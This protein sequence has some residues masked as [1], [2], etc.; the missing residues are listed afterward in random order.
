MRARKADAAT[1]QRHGVPGGEARELLQDLAN[2]TAELCKSVV[3]LVELT[4][5]LPGRR[6]EEL[7][8]AAEALQASS[9]DRHELVARAVQR[10]C[11]GRVLAREKKPFKRER[12]RA[13]DIKAE[14]E[15]ARDRPFYA[16][17]LRRIPLPSIPLTPPPKP[18][19]AMPRE[20]YE[21]LLSLA[22]DGGRKPNNA[23]EVSPPKVGRPPHGPGA[24]QTKP[25]EPKEAVALTK[26]PEEISAALSRRA[27]E[28][29][30]QCMTGDGSLD[31][32]R[33]RC[34]LL[35]GSRR[36]NQLTLSRLPYEAL[37]RL[38][39]GSPAEA[40]G[41][42]AEVVKGLF[43][44]DT[45]N[46]AM[47]AEGGR[48]KR[49]WSQRPLPEADAAER[50]T[51]IGAALLAD[52]VPLFPAAVRAIRPRPLDRDEQR[53]PRVEPGGEPLRIVGDLG[54]FRALLSLFSNGL[55][56]RIPWDA[57]VVLGGSAVTAC[58][59]V[60]EGVLEEWS[61]RLRHAALWH[62][63]GAIRS[64]LIKCLG[65]RNAPGSLP[66]AAL[67]LDFAHDRRPPG[68]EALGKRLFHNEAGA[69]YNLADIDLFFVAPTKAKAAASLNRVQLELQSA[70]ERSQSGTG[71]GRSHVAVRTPN[72]VT[73]CPRFPLRHVQL[74]LRVAEDMGEH[75]ANADLDCTSVCY[76]GQTVWATPRAIRAFETGFNLVSNQALLQRK[77]L[78][79]R[80]A[81]YAQ[82]GFGSM[83]YEL[84]RHEPR[85]DVEVDEK[86]RAK[87]EAARRPRRSPGFTKVP[88][89][90]NTAEVMVELTMRGY[91]LL[92]IPRGPAVTPEAISLY[93]E[94]REEGKRTLTEVTSEVAWGGLA[95]WRR[96]RP[97]QPIFGEE[98]A[99][100][101]GAPQSSC[102]CCGSVCS[103]DRTG[104]NGAT[105]GALAEATRPA[106]SDAEAV[107]GDIRE[108]AEAST[109]GG[110]PSGRLSVVPICQVC[111]DMNADRRA[112]AVDLR[113]YT[114][115]VTGG[116]CK[117]GYEA[118]LKLLRCGALVVAST[119]FP[120]CAAQNFLSEPD[121]ASW[122]GR[123]HIYGIDFSDLSLLRAFIAQ[124]ARYYPV[125]IL[126]NN[127][128]QT[129]RRPTAY[130][131]Q[132]FERE[133][134]LLADAA[135]GGLRTAE[136]VRPVGQSPWASGRQMATPP[137][138]AAA[139]S[140][141]HPAAGPAD[142]TSAVG[143]FAVAPPALG[144][145][146]VASPT[147]EAPAWGTSTVVPRQ[148]LLDAAG[149]ETAQLFPAGRQ[150]LHGEPL[151]LRPSSSWTAT[152][153][154]GGVAE[155]ELL[156]VLAVNAAAPFM[157][158]QGLLPVLRQP[159]AGSVGEES[160]A[161]EGRFIVNVTSA[162]GIFSMDG[163]AS[164]TAEHPH[165]NMAK[166][167]LNMLTKTS[168]PE[169]SQYGIYC[170]AV[171]PG[172]VSMMRPGSPFEAKRPLPPL[173]V[174]DGAARV[175][176]PIMDG[177][178]ALRAGRRPLHG[179]LFRNYVVAPW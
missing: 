125:D 172:W 1:Q 122:V 121:A 129:I 137:A 163:S 47:L 161:A 132:L 64:A 35:A 87:L 75:L 126:V 28:E 26:E 49:A 110:K 100:N 102:Y 170:T 89:A 12:L 131:A 103:S 6:R 8:T 56:D 171:D 7:I 156:E 81:K 19:V 62:C 107:D 11:Q 4:E 135:G 63:P 48:C 36:L 134:A 32:A 114:A 130:Y 144:E 65:G 95:E 55:L 3:E 174:A 16:G 74:V 29:A 67:I 142:E 71:Q 179:V 177:V 119:R 83:V 33:L 158:F 178:R 127:A 41:V 154:R 57:G 58:L 157:L 133:Q 96:E 10:S 176:A 22:A 76:D 112:H 150:D 123:L 148:A 20:R 79:D 113:G 39:E 169:L 124:I 136:L 160:V 90:S 167:A 25:T 60:P 111:C 9:V 15:L 143:A 73:L 40:I 98:G 54:I 44:G 140:S 17:P 34:A 24:P 117:I 138:L 141:N 70:M 99:V 37:R 14:K 78:P 166:A 175:V 152:L 151:D 147:G 59:A 31:L 149:E 85:C 52:R 168:A 101:G 38:A 77:D 27:Q 61:E 145:A 118:C 51:S 91:D 45:V 23:V 53:H 105:V 42:P 92:H 146:G 80:I 109:S 18:Y 82:R 104:A 164:K 5:H 159:R 86:T 120:H 88:L 139:P 115:V 165:T 153:C 106:G 68:L 108:P 43:L 21:R 46:S 128:A 162:E 93:L 2:E 173:S 116:R 84:C 72:S 30:L 94:G 13:K 69:P 97:Q 50:P 155:R 66:A